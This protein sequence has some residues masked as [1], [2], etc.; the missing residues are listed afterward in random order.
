MSNALDRDEIIEQAAQ[1]VQNGRLAVLTSEE[2]ESLSSLLG[3]IAVSIME[4]GA[5]V[6]RV[7]A[8]AS[9]AAIDVVAA[10]CR[11][12][13]VSSKELIAGLRIRGETGN[14]VCLVI[15][16][17]ECLEGKAFDVLRKLLEGTSGGVGMLLGGEPDVALY[18]EDAGVAATYEQSV[19]AC[20]LPVD[21]DVADEAST[22]GWR[23]L[24]WRHFAAAAG[25]ALLVVLFWVS[26]G[27]EVAD[28]ETRELALP[29]EQTPVAL[30]VLPAP[31]APEK[32][33]AVL[34]EPLVEAPELVP[35]PEVEPMP[36]PAPSPEPLPP[37]A[38]VVKATPKPVVKVP[39]PAPLPA[40]PEL[41]GASADLGYRQEEWL[42]TLPPGNWMLQVA[43]ASDEDGARKLL[44]Q[45]GRKRSGYYRADRS[46]R[47]MF[48]VL[49]GDWSSRE[50]AAAGKSDLPATLQKL[51]P[52]PRELAAIQKEI[53]ATP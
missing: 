44:D 2:P 12:L 47:Q 37:P 26:S 33:V 13:E 19:D 20:E 31:V 10:V 7:D 32:D 1:V 51:G 52:F 3:D 25:L 43:L 6:I 15:D 22:I 42:L 11:Y 34:P 46:G 17:G 14:P 21:D 35:E 4:F 40:E 29:S 36:K 23:Q 39:A 16:N 48:V 28:S 30:K 9:P 38:E 45:I 53:G 27:E 18:L 24:P 8:Y 49:A 50:A 5:D 41:T